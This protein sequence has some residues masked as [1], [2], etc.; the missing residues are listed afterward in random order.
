MTRTPLA[1]AT[2]A[3]IRTRTQEACAPLRTSHGDNVHLIADMGS[4]IALNRLATA[5]CD[6][7]LTH[8]KQGK[9]PKHGATLTELYAV[10][11]AL[12]TR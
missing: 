8:I 3:D 12:E 1:T 2:A 5:L 4:T 11:R 9:R 6:A 7:D 10:I